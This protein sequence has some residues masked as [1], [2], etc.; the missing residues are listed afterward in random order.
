MEEQDQPPLD[1]LESGLQPLGKADGVTRSITVYSNGIGLRGAP[2]RTLYNLLDTNDAQGN[3]GN[4]NRVLYAPGMGCITNGLAT[5]CQLLGASQNGNF[6]YEAILHGGAAGT[7]YDLLDQ[8]AQ[9]S[10]VSIPWLACESAASSQTWCGIEASEIVSI[11]FDGLEDSGDDFVY[12]GWAISGG[13]ATTTD[14]FR[15]GGEIQQR[16]PR[17]IADD[18][19]YVLTIEPRRGDDPAPAATHLLAGALELGGTTNLTTEHDAALGTDFSSASGGYILATPSSAADDDDTQGIWFLDPVAGEATLDLPSLPDGWVY[20]GW[21]VTSDGP[22]STGRFLE[23]TGEDSD[24]AGPSA[25][26]NMTPPFPGQD[27][28]SPATDLLG[29]TVV[30]SVEPQPDNSAAP[31]AIKPLIDPSVEDVAKPMQQALGN[32]S[33]NRP[34]AV[35]TF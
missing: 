20:E 13:I 23:P 10:F 22:V 28:I 5:Y 34:S 21:V 26:P 9:E 30:I 8:G 12:E 25:G 17:S 32:T 16:I 15:R 7:L 27:F 31:F 1:E 4:G 14:R 33:E 18:S 6:S 11:S 29:T 3:V 19:L 2:A 35:A 24:G